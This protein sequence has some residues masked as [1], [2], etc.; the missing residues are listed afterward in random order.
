MGRFFRK[1]LRKIPLMLSFEELLVW[2][3]GGFKVPAPH[4][5]KMQVLKR[6]AFSAPWVETGTYEGAT[7][8]WLARRYEGVV[9]LE[10]DFQLF[11]AT[12]ERLS[13]ER[14]IRI[15]NKSSEDGFRHAIEISASA[16]LNFWLDGHWSGG[17]TYQGVR[18]TPIE[19]ELKAISEYYDGT[20]LTHCAVFVDDARLFAVEHRENLSD[21]DRAG[22]PGLHLLCSW[23]E[24]MGFSWT[25]EHDIFIAKSPP[26]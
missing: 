13:T 22:Y 14:N 19:F 1:L 25:I 3:D 4:Q 9:S 24:S 7:T 12:A 5:V 10:P 26:P 8:L 23:A 17:R 20:R 21:G 15:L 6:H 11:S 16:V 18:D 2:K